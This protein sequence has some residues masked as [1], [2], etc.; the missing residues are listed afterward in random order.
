M[1]DLA[2]FLSGQRVGTI[3]QGSGLRFRYDEAYLA[4]ARTLP[5]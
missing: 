2:V 3:S 5:E 4:Q 1:K